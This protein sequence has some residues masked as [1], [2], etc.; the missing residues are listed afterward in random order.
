MRL[1]ARYVQ[2]EVKVSPDAV[3]PIRLR[4]GGFMFAM[5]AVEALDLA[6][7]I[8]DAVAELKP[9]KPPRALEIFNTGK[10]PS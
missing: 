1:N 10:E 6:N 4:V 5:E 2:P 9:P 3:L 7:Q 8:A